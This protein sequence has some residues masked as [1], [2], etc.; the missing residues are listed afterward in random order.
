MS[1]I[2]VRDNNDDQYSN[3]GFSGFLSARPNLNPVKIR[4]M[5]TTSDDIVCI[6]VKPEHHS[7]PFDHWRDD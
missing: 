4:Y 1:D 3:P 7:D 6:F 5:R 2:I